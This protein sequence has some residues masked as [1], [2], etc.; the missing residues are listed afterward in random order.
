MGAVVTLALAVLFLLLHFLLS[1]C[2]LPF[3]AGGT[4]NGPFPKQYFWPS[5]ILVKPPDP[6]RNAKTPINT[7]DF[8]SKNFA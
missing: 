4:T 6:H 5:Q 3:F 7:G 1:F 8:S 2:L